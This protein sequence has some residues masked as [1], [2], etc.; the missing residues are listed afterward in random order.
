MPFFPGLIIIISGR[1]VVQ[2]WPELSVFYGKDPVIAGV[3]VKRSERV[4]KSHKET[5]LPLRCCLGLQHGIQIP[6]L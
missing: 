4:R 1:E 5:L 2:E 6:I 3:P